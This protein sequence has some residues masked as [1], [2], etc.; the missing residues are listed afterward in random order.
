MKNFRAILSDAGELTKFRI[1]LLSLMMASLGFFL[2]SEGHVALGL[3]RNP[4]GIGPSGIF[5][6][7][8]E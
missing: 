6:W 7:N 1:V 5:L 3:S 4:R 2:G 8:F